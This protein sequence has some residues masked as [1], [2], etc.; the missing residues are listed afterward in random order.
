MAP[1]LTTAAAIP[2]PATGPLPVSS[3]DA[4]SPPESVKDIYTPV[5]EKV[6][7]ETPSEGFLQA[8]IDKNGEKVLVTW[9]HAEQRR[10]VR[11]ADF[12]FLPIFTVSQLYFVARVFGRSND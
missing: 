10:V 12:L 5:E 2:L 8:Y 1:V 4:E 11:K 6:D 7:V 9:T 3:V